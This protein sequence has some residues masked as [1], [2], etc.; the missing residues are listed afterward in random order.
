MESNR[1]SSKGCE[2]KKI[3]R[4][5]IFDRSEAS[6]Q[7]TLINRYEKE[8]GYLVLKL[9]QVQKAGYPDLLL[10]KPNGEIRFVEVKA[11]KGRLSKIQEYRI[12][13]LKDQG[14][15]VEIAQSSD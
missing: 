14:F 10:L 4:S 9:I 2:Q 7:K 12:N 15:T 6:Y 8:E 1:E 11:K 5:V 13:E 3:L